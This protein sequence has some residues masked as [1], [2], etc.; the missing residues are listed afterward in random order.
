MVDGVMRW[1]KSLKEKYE[2]TRAFGR[3]DRTKVRKGTLEIWSVKF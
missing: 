2:W 3:E 1:K